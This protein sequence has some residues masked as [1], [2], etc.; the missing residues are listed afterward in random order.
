MEDRAHAIIAVSFLILFGAGATFV[1][2]WMQ[3]GTPQVKDYVIVSPYS[4]SGLAIDAPVQ[5]K[6]VQVGTVKAVRLD[7][8]NAHRILIRIALVAAA[9]VTHATYAQI[10]SAGITGGSYIALVDGEGNQTPLPTSSQHPARIPIRPGLVAKL[11]SSGKQLLSRSNQLSQH[12]NQLLDARNRAHVA[13]ML[14]N[15]DK[16]TAKLVRLED[17]AMAPLRTLP[18]LAS[19]AHQTLAQGQTLLKSLQGD[20]DALHGVLLAAG[21]TTRKVNTDTLDRVDR[22]TRDMDR[23]LGQ[24]DALTRELRRDPQSVLFGAPPSAPGPGEPGYHPPSGNRH[25]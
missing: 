21:S 19:Q 11:E 15:L 5:Y 1:A 7:P 9:P 10:S 3:S 8:Q 18:G 16:A 22:L 13:A 23:T 6:G 20:A 4:V 17:A 2:W 14:A 12:L 24:I 25:P